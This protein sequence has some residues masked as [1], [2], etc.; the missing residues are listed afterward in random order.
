M[1]KTN[2]GAMVPTPGGQRDDT[3]RLEAAVA[4][5]RE[6]LEEY[7]RARVLFL[8]AQTQQ[9]LALVHLAFFRKDRKLRHL[10]AALHAVD[11]ALEEYRKANAAFY[12][13]EA[14][15]VRQQILAAKGGVRH[16]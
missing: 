7:T 3:A 1:A 15:H 11:G 4:A 5:Y 9:N 8:W 2:P 12:I 14:E 6:V 10:D 13:D 16:G